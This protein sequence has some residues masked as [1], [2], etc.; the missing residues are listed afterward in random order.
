[1]PGLI[2]RVLWSGVVAG[3]ASGVAAAA[4]G[5]LESAPGRPSTL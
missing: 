5:R 3:I 4:L 1:M 2:E